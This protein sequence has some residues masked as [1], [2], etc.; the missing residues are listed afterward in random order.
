MSGQGQV[1]N[2]DPDY[3][4]DI[5]A[6]PPSTSSLTSCN[7]TSHTS[8]QL[9]SLAPLWVLF[10]QSGVVG[11]MALMAATLTVDEFEGTAF[12]KGRVHEAVEDHLVTPDFLLILHEEA[13][14]ELLD[15]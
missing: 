12:V 6:E 11:S 10:R 13:A 3:A 1:T 4:L 7:I 14:G 2:I 5:K 15:H 8:T 9:P